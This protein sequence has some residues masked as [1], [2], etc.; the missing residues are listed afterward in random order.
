MW[1]FVV[2]A[3]AVAVPA[4]QGLRGTVAPTIGLASGVMSCVSLL[5]GARFGWRARQTLVEDRAREAA[6]LALVMLAGVLRDRSDAELEALSAREGPTGE[7]ARLVLERR[8]E[9][10]RRPPRT[11]PPPPTR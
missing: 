5:L 7:A 10:A 4:F 11:A 3:A 1:F 8:R 9:D 6:R 2:V